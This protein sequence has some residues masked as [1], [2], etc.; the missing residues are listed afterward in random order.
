MYM[1]THTNTHT[2]NTHAYIHRYTVGCACAYALQALNLV[3]QNPFD[4]S[5][6]LG[7]HL[8]SP[9]LYP[10]PELGVGYNQDA[11][12]SKHA[13][14]NSP[15]GHVSFV[16]VLDFLCRGR[17]AACVHIYTV[18]AEQCMN[19]CPGTTV[20]IRVLDFFAEGA[21]LPPMHG[22]PRSSTG[23]A[24][25]HSEA[26]NPAIDGGERLK[27]SLSGTPPEL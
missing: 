15:S 22:R 23:A 19:T 16:C 11:P 18:S 6:T 3:I 5:H 9:T 27:P 10:T 2:H 4:A 21:L 25:S 17:A 24:A 26:P 8:F 12:A 7:P 13:G 14:T 1:Y 20:G